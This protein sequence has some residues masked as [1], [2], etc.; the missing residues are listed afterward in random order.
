MANYPI[1]PDDVFQKTNGLTSKWTVERI[2]EF[3]D[4]PVH[5]RLVEQ[6]G[7]ERIIT[8]AMATL[9][10]TQQWACIKKAAQK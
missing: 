3:P 4:I 9:L 7:N 1:Q 10:D 5:V 2:L 8:I 6:G